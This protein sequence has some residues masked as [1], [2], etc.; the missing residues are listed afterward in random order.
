[1]GNIN[2][3]YSE[4]FHAKLAE[5]NIVAP[6][7]YIKAELKRLY[8][9]NLRSRSDPNHISQMDIVVATSEETANN[10]IQYRTNTVLSIATP[11]HE[12]SPAVT[13]MPAFTQ[14]PSNEP[15]QSHS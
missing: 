15:T 12:S 1:M 4:Q 13:S 3:W 14:I 5:M 9:A 10:V 8:V 2:N 11:I 7:N 6:A